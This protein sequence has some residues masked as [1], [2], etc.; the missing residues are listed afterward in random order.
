[1]AGRDFAKDAAEVSANIGDLVWLEA[2]VQDFA[3]G[4][5]EESACTRGSTASAVSLRCGGRS[6]MA[7][8][9]PAVAVRNFTAKERDCGFSTHRSA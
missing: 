6:N 7:P 1:V 2:L 8:P 4:G 9:A 3:D 5:R